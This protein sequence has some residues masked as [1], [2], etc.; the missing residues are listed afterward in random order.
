[1]PLR[2]K[3]TKKIFHYYILSVFVPWWRGKQIAVQKT[4]YKN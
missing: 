3:G 4:I 1:M 2:H